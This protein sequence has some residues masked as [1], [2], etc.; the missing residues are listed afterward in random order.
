MLKD[1]KAKRTPYKGEIFRS[2]LEARWAIF[3]DELGIK[4][5]YEPEYSDV[6]FRGG[7]TYYKPDYFLP[8]YELWVEIKPVDTKQISEEDFGKIVGWTKQE[9][10]MLVLI[11]TPKILSDNSRPHYIFTY[12]EKRKKPLNIQ[13][14]VRWCECPKCGKIDYVP[15]GGIPYDCRRTCYLDLFGEELPEPDGHKSQRLKKACQKANN[16]DFN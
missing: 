14:L 5:K 3:F 9:L 16:H 8:D 2:R 6:E 12:D 15:G 13:P 7:R 11:G 10:E 4:W 1:I